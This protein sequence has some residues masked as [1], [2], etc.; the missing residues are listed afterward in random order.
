MSAAPEKMPRLSKRQLI[1]CGLIFASLFGAGCGV[2]K[3]EKAERAEV[4]RQKIDRKLRK[5]FNPATAEIGR[6]AVRF[7]RSNPSEGLI[8]DTHGTENL[9]ISRS[10]GY[11]IEISLQKGISAKNI[12]AGDVKD[13]VISREESGILASEVRIEPAEENA[14]ICAKGGFIASSERF[15]AKSEEGELNSFIT[16]NRCEGYILNP[17]FDDTTQELGPADAA[18]R[19]INEMNLHFNEA[20]TE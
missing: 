6:K 17:N 12:K 14:G 10:N 1:A 8:Y 16:T 5:I 7:I 20:I 15:E 9:S 4:K 19:I 11:G 18:E 2:S 13:V 3:S